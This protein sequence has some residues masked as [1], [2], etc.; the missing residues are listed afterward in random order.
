MFFHRYFVFYMYQVRSCNFFT[1]IIFS[2]NRRC[3]RF[4]SIQTDTVPQ[5]HKTT[6]FHKHSNSGS[7]VQSALMRCIV[8]AIVLCFSRK[9][10]SFVFRQ[11][12]FQYQL[13]VTLHHAFISSLG[14]ILVHNRQHVSEMNNC[15]SKSV[16]IQKCC[17][18]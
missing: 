4:L 10:N 8:A 18:T 11:L 15:D 14:T 6:L 12:L 9:C 1:P 5:F 3:K 7:S 2:F 13:L 17:L 16:V